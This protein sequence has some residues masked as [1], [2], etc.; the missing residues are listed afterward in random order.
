MPEQAVVL[1]AT[2][3]ET[4]AV[5]ADAVNRDLTVAVRG[6]GQGW[7]TQ[8]RAVPH[9]DLVVETT[10]LNQVIEHTAG[11][12]VARVQAGATM[13]HVAEVLAAHGQRLSLDVPPEITVGGMIATGTAGPLRFRYGAPRD[14]LI[15]ITVVRPDGVIAHSGGKVVKNVAG[16]DLG[17]LFAGSHGT[18][19]LIA[20]ATFRLHPLPESV[21]YLTAE[22]PSAAAAAEA[23]VVITGSAMQPSA[24][25][26]H[27][28]AGAG[29]TVGVLL[30][31]TSS[32]VA[33]RAR[34]LTGLLRP[35]PVTV[36]GSPPD[37]WGTLPVSG[38]GVGQVARTTFWLSRL[39]EVLGLI[40]D[41]DVRCAAGG[42]A[43]AG[44]LYLCPEDGGDIAGLIASLRALLGSRG[45]ASVL[46][47]PW[48][49]ADALMHAVKDQFDP[50]G[51]FG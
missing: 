13:G 3:D 43:G 47:D 39:G 21:T 48:A 19:G 9:A 4:S 49:P 7:P 5:L 31:G 11:D 8:R 22:F 17:K 41:A 32:G 14:L 28:P 18:L 42:S 51:R 29:L 16:Y 26:L 34:Q 15:G 30:E 40:A 1:P 10:K 25:E 46:T 27:W 24:V 12:L 33:E 20:E 6:A 37:W 50:T 36:S 44:L 38:V 23:V 35:G 45:D 2:L